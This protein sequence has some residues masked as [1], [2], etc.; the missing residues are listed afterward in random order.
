[1]I[2]GRRW[3]SAVTTATSLVAVGAGCGRSS[4]EPDTRTPAQYFQE[5]QAATVTP[6][7]KIVKDSVQEE[8]DKIEYRTEDG[9]RWRVGYSKHA[10]GGYHYDTPE[11]IKAPPAK[12]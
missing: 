1:M 8:S 9:R 2:P 10:G 11:E 6:H 4:S 12:Q 5:Q 7:G 3:L